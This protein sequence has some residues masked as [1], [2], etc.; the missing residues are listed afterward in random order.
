M[1]ASFKLPFTGHSIQVAP[2]IKPHVFRFPDEPVKQ[3]LVDEAVS[4]GIT[5]DFYRLTNKQIKQLL[6]EV[7]A[8]H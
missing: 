3:A 8:G 2:T 1:R 5:R 7:K 6:S 4:L